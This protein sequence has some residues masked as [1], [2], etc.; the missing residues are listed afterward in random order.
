MDGIKVQSV[1]AMQTN[2]SNG[3]KQVGLEYQYSSD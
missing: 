3:L 1:L 2:I